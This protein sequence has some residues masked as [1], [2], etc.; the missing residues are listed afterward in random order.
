MFLTKGNICILWLQGCALVSGC[1]SVIIP[2]PIVLISIELG[3][4]KS[5]YVSNIIQKNTLFE[6]RLHTSILGIDKLMISTHSLLLFGSEITD[7]ERIFL[8]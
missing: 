7:R 8:I 5:I 3:N 1:S 4:Y 2:L 6:N